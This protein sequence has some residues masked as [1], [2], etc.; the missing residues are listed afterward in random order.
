MEQ[1]SI[2]LLDSS[3]FAYSFADGIYEYHTVFQLEGEN[4]NAVYSYEQ[5]GPGSSGYALTYR[6]IFVMRRW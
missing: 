6:D 1:I 5:L 4:L 3:H 2:F